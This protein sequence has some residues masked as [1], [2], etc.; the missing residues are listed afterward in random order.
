M[1]AKIR[2][3]IVGGCLGSTKA[4]HLSELYYRV[5]LRRFEA[6]GYGRLSFAL[7][8]YNDPPELL[9]E[10]RQLLE[11]KEIDV[12]VVQLRPHPLVRS[13]W[14]L[15]WTNADGRRG[16]VSLHP[17][18]WDRSDT[19]YDTT[20]F[21]YKV[22]H[23][24]LANGV[25]PSSAPGRA[26]RWLKKGNINS[27]LGRLVGL[28][29]WALRQHLDLLRG[30]QR[31]CLAAGARLIVMG[32]APMPIMPSA[33]D[34]CRRASRKFAESLAAAGVDYVEMWGIRDSEGR[35]V[36]RED[37]QHLNAVGHARLAD[38][39]EPPLERVLAEVARSRNAV[40]AL[41]VEE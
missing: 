19:G 38:L 24:P 41:A 7:S 30:L 14:L 4:V 39:L 9:V 3:G 20:K 11:R 6:K 26:G 18:L 35:P 28:Q 29:R 8:G 17:A 27:L 13:A 34:F 40:S 1:T 25:P 32:P 16:G 2:I 12:L 5:L 37:A 23:G 21:S 22:T 31:D 36:I 33:D 10:A 15:W